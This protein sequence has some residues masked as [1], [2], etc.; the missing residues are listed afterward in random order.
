MK[1]NN[2]H[3]I[4]EAE[5]SMRQLNKNIAINKNIAKSMETDSMQ[6]KLN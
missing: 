3:A 6:R 4:F 2:K 1:Q 5:Q